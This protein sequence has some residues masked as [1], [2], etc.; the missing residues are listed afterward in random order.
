MGLNYNTELSTFSN[1]LRNRSQPLQLERS[2]FSAQ[3]RAIFTASG[4][5]SRASPWIKIPCRGGHALGKSHCSPEEISDVGTPP[6][7]QHH[8]HWYF[9]RQ[10]ITLRKNIIGID[11]LYKSTYTFDLTNYSIGM[12]IIQLTKNLYCSSYYFIYYQSNIHLEKIQNA[13]FPIIL[14]CFILVD[15]N[16]SRYVHTKM[17]N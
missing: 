1:I 2:H 5:S 14:L 8:S 16:Y 12:H 15:T 4:V 10:H 17:I 9:L 13:D 11:T 3:W 6:D 7:Q